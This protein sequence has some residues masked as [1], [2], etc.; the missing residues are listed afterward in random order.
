MKLNTKMWDLYAILSVLSCSQN[1]VALPDRL[2][3][4]FHY[5][6]LVSTFS[7]SLMS[8]GWFKLVRP[9]ES[10]REIQKKKYLSIEKKVNFNNEKNTSSVS[11]LCLSELIKL[12][13]FDWSYKLSKWDLI[14]RKDV[15]RETINKWKIDEEFIFFG[16]VS[17]EIFINFFKHSL[18]KKRKKINLFLIEY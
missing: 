9:L 13:L 5:S 12:I 1:R 14:D 7:Y 8:V 16:F 3:K 10:N 6:L 18:V 11:W 15:M 4:I 17:C 2:Q